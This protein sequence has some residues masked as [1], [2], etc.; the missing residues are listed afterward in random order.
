MVHRAAAWSPALQ[1][2][3]MPCWQVE[4]PSWDTGMAPA[5]P[6]PGGASKVWFLG[7]SS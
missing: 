4:G 1:S 6:G 5:Q 7:L 3:A 2:T